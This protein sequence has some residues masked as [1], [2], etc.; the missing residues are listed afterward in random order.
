MAKKCTPKADT[1][2]TFEER[3]TGLQNQQQR[4]QQP[5]GDELTRACALGT[6]YS[7]FGDYRGYGKLVDMTP[8]QIGVLR[9]HYRYVHRAAVDYLIRLAGSIGIDGTPL[10]SAGTACRLL[11]KQEGLLDP[12]A[13]SHLWPTCLGKQLYGLPQGQQT[14]IEAGEQVIHKIRLKLG[15]ATAPATEQDGP[16]DGNRFRF[17]GQVHEMSPVPW[18]LLA[19]MW[20]RDERDMHDVEEEVWEVAG[21]SQLDDAKHDLKAFL[22]GIGYP[23]FVSKARR[24]N[25]LIWKAF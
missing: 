20:E 16:L 15:C 7:F 3:I 8:F 12:D 19:A 22:R 4:F 25:S 23:R 1:H 17:A 10:A 18:K 9:D 6:W 21:G 24:S 11:A 5:P 14:A 2:Y 13:E